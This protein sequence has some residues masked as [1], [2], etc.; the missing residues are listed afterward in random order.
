MRQNSTFLKTTARSP[1]MQTTSQRI[2]CRVLRDSMSLDPAYSNYVILARG[3][4][5]LESPED[6]R[7]NTCAL[8]YFHLS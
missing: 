1:E 6:S 8:R 3:M 7:L 4:D 5:A 2:L